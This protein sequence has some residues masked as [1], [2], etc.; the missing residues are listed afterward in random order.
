MFIKK[1][2]GLGSPGDTEKLSA[3]M[4]TSDHCAE[5]TSKLKE[6]AAIYALREIGHH[7][8]R[9]FEP[10]NKGSFGYNQSF[11]NSISKLD[12]PQVL[13]AEI[14]YIKTLPTYNKFLHS[15]FWADLKSKIDNFC[16]HGV[17]DG[18]Y[19]FS[20]SN[21]THCVISAPQPSNS[22]ENA[23]F[24]F[25]LVSDIYYGDGVYESTMLIDGKYRALSY[26]ETAMLTVALSEA[27][28]CFFGTSWGIF[29]LRTSRFDLCSYNVSLCL[30]PQFKQIEK[31]VVPEKTYRDIY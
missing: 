23:D 18:M 20:P 4:M 19:T 25:K 27:F 9:Y 24:Q 21:I 6:I 22:K 8:F 3:R 2:F 10:L 5:V 14:D 28:P 31:P 13:H 11:V 7:S 26:I 17:K 15:T 29:A 16:V 12:N 1:I 30:I